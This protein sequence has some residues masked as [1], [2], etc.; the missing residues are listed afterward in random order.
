MKENYGKTI[1][2]QSAV[3]TKTKDRGSYLQLRKTISNIRSLRERKLLNRDPIHSRP[4]SIL[5][6]IQLLKIVNNFLLNIF[7]F[8][9]NTTSSS[10]SSYPINRLTGIGY[11]MEIFCVMITSFQPF[12]SRMLLPSKLFLNN[13]SVKLILKI[14]S[15]LPFFHFKI[16]SLPSLLFQSLPSLLSLGFQQAADSFSL[17]KNK[18]NCC[19][20]FIFP[21]TLISYTYLTITHHL[22]YINIV[23]DV[24][25]MIVTRSYSLLHICFY[26]WNYFFLFSFFLSLIFQ[27]FYH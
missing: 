17:S 26:G 16:T 20:L 24:L 21:S 12:V 5:T 1:R 25:H 18:K 10:N 9:S 19:N 7:S 13:K 23:N 27:L 14:F 22:W 4:R 11:S 6:L 8:F 15:T 3:F 2:I